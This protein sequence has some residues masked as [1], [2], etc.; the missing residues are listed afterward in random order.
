MTNFKCICT[1]EKKNVC[2]AKASEICRFHIR[3]KTLC[4]KVSIQVG[5]NEL[6]KKKV[7]GKCSR[8]SDL[9]K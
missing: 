1:I 3:K 8:K 5:G 9:M 6:S 7:G 2:N 4:C